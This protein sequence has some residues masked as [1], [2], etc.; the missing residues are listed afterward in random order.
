[1]S[2]QSVLRLFGQQLVDPDAARAELESGKK[3]GTADVLVAVYDIPDTHVAIGNTEKQVIDRGAFD[4]FAGRSTDAVRPF[5]LDHGE[6]MGGYS[7]SALMIGKGTN[8]RSSSDGLVIG[9]EWNLEKQAAREAFSDLLFAPEVWQFSF[10][11]RVSDEVHAR[12]DG[13][14]HVTE[15]KDF[16]EFSQVVWGAQGETGVLAETIAARMG[17]PLFREYVAQQVEIALRGEGEP[18]VE[19]VEPPADPPADPPVPPVE[20]PA[21]PLP[22]AAVPG[23]ISS[24]NV[25]KT[26][27]AATL[28]ANRGA[29]ALELRD[30][31]ESREA[32]KGILEEAV[33]PDAVTDF[34]DQ[35]WKGHKLLT[36]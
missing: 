2:D 12:R 22:A 11:N 10:R 13:Q 30:D 15:F 6:F 9:A 7:K 20:P 32:L 36:P 33:R 5:F 8:F 23:L 25:S 14:D 4:A 35:V 31:P 29:L 27:E 19:P 18:P 17:D 1:M 21:E 3:V 26:F 28:L 24:E 34:F 16:A